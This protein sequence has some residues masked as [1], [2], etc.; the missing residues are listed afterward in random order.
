MTNLFAWRDT[1]PL[2]MKRVEYPVGQDNDHHILQC[3]S[4]AGLVVAAWGNH[5]A[6][7]N[8]DLSVRQCLSQPLVNVKLHCFRMT[9]KGQP[10]HPLYMPG[11]LIPKP[12][13]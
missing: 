11:N 10:E 1:D 5:G 8:R 6:H 7:H 3:A 13:P 9:G 2:A 4:G 12:M